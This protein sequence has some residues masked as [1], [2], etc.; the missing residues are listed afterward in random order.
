MKQLDLITGKQKV[1]YY[2]EPQL[3][4]PDA[5]IQKNSKF[6]SKYLYS[7]C[8]VV[9]DRVEADGGPYRLVKTR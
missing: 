8:V 6:N 5:K 3:V 4:I 2:L 1:E 7:P 9:K